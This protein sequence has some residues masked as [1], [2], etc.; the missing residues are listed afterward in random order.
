MVGI[1]EQAVERQVEMPVFVLSVEILGVRA[2][3]GM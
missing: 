2:L 1:P 3:V